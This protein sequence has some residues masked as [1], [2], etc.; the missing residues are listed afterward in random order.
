MAI[1]KMQAPTC[2]AGQGRE[3]SIK[4]GSDPV[5]VLLPKSV[6]PG[7]PGGNPPPSGPAIVLFSH[8]E[9]IGR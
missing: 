5:V 9:H 8:A 1:D 4:E 6:T 2:K 7:K 3:T